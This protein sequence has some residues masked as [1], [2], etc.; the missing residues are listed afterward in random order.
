MN[1]LNVRETLSLTFL[2]LAKKNV[3]F[4]LTGVEDKMKPSCF[5]SLLGYFYFFVLMLF[6]ISNIIFMWVFLFF[7]PSLNCMVVPGWPDHTVMERVYVN[8][9]PA[10]QPFKTHRFHKRV[11][12]LKKVTADGVYR[13]CS[14]LRKTFTLYNHSVHSDSATFLL[15]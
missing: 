8:A 9:M 6:T 3:A 13:S 12:Y 1:A 5:P 14:S 15:H 11:I 10:E 2:S 4:Q 7:P